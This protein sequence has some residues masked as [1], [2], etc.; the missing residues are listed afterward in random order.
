[1]LAIDGRPV[2]TLLP[3][4]QQFISGATEAWGRFLALTRLAEGQNNTEVELEIQSRTTGKE[5]AKRLRR[6]APIG[7]FPV[8]PPIEK[9]KELG[10]GIYYVDL[11]RL[12]D[13]EAESLCP[14]LAAAKGIILNVRGYT[15]TTSQFLGHFTDTALKSQQFHIPLVLR[16]DRESFSFKPY[17]QWS[18]KP[19]T[20]QIRAKTAFLINARAMSHSETDM[21][22]VSYYR[23]GAL[24][25]EATAGTNG[26]LV[27]VM[28]PG[29]YELRWTGLKTLNQDGSQHHGIGIQPTV[30]ASRS[31]KGIAEGRDELLEAAIRI[32]AQENASEPRFT[33]AGSPSERTA[34]SK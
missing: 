12:S 5:Y 21:A 24:V 20:P 1:L 34:G 29:G 27:Q 14:K 15:R 9:F 4:K 23:L 17:E 32:V 13:P 11:T 16:P 8:D 33:D 10:P 22:F 18:I 26:D 28:L 6:S 7:A 25:G 31:I 2:D 30:P 19:L 3:E